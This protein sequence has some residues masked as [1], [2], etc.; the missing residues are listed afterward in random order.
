MDSLE[1][2][3]FRHSHEDM[4]GE[5]LELI[6]EREA[7][8]L[9]EQQ[10]AEFIL[11]HYVMA[12][13][14]RADTH[15][16]IPLSLASYISKVNDLPSGRILEAAIPITPEEEDISLSADRVVQL[17]EAL[18]ELAP[19]V[20][21]MKSEDIVDDGK[22]W[23]TIQPYGSEARRSKKEREDE[24]WR[25]METVPAS[26]AEYKGMNPQAKESRPVFYRIVRITIIVLCFFVGM[27]VMGFSPERILMQSS[28]AQSIVNS[29]SKSINSIIGNDTETY[30]DNDANSGEVDNAKPANDSKMG[31]SQKAEIFDLR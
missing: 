22:P 2:P 7:K 29:I 4:G 18:A 16:D 19:D 28:V 26:Y 14:A 23:I 20:R 24:L 5:Q 12:A 8:I 10:E 21:R 13:A 9:G 3:R 6:L 30:K 1:N 31:Q 15:L 25:H 11:F 27:R 17:S